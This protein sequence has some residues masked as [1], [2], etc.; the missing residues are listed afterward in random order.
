MKF[1]I[2]MSCIFSVLI[3]L[4]NLLKIKNSEHLG[5]YEDIRRKINPFNALNIETSKHPN[6]KGYRIVTNM[7]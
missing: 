2:E 5:I 3:T 6:V 7:E 1:Y 4:K